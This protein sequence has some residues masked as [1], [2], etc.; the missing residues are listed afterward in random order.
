MAWAWGVLDKRPAWFYISV[1]MAQS[2]ISAFV[3][4][5]TREQLEQFAEAH[6]VKKAY[7]VEQ[8]LL[9]HL[10]A[11]RQLPADLI[12]PAQVAVDA[13]SLERVGKLMRAPRKPTSALRTLM[14]KR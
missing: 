11:L 13:T 6:G 10:Q 5:A 2:Q 7:V 1:E 8:A 14:R 3:S 9:H 4:D 12:I